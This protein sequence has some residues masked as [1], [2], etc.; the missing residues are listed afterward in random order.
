MAA[1]MKPHPSRA[2]LYVIAAGVL[3]ALVPLMA[4]CWFSL[5]NGRAGA[6]FRAYR[7]V[8]ADPAFRESFA[9]SLQVAAGTI[10]LTIT[11]V[12][13]TGFWVHLRLPRLRPVVG[14]V[15]TLPMVVPPIALVVGLIREFSWA[16]AWLYGS[17][18][19]LVGAYSVLALP[20]AHRAID[21]G[22][23]SLNIRTLTEAA[24]CLGAG[25][26]TIFRTIVLPNL[27]SSV[28]TAALLTFAIVMG[29]FT[30]AVIMQ[31]TTFSVYMSYVWESRATGAAALSVLSFL[32]TWTGML[33]IIVVGNRLGRGMTQIGGTR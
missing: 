9:L 29:E 20:Y 21:N 13:V 12:T 8:L 33:A 24:R 14:F 30:I 1:P 2:G 16:P 22:L 26:P 7:E 6:S 4:T 3:Y 10:V 18:A 31:F 32:I 19:V 15:A 28:L 25:W 17:Y 11:L 5:R 23:D 27:R